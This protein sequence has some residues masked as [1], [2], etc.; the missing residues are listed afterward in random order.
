MRAAVPPARVVLRVARGAAAQQAALAAWLAA[1][2]AGRRAV[3]AE[4]AFTPL[5][6]PAEVEIA[7]LAA[8]CVCCLGLVPLRVALTRLLRSARPR[9]LLLLV[10]SDAHLPRLRALLAGGELGLLDLVDAPADGDRAANPPE[11]LR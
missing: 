9:E 3:I 4:G 10:A 1:T 2:P 5:D 7:R 11:E 6:A 8:G